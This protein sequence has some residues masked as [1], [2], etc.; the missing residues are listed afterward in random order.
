MLI[1]LDLDDVSSFL[2]TELFAALARIQYPLW[3]GGKKKPSAQVI[4]EGVI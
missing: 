2:Q 4:A 3:E 1:S